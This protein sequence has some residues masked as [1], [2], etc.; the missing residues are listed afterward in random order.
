MS[1]PDFLIIGAMKSGT[2]T[3]AAQLS[4]QNGIFVTTPKEPN[5]FSDDSVFAKG[6]VWYEALFSNAGPDEIKGEA[7]TH[8]TKLPTYPKTVERAAEFLE[9]PKLVYIIRNPID[10]AISHYMHEWTMGNVSGDI[11]LEFERS[12]EILDYGCYGMQ[13]RPWIESFGRHAVHLVCLEEMQ[14]DP[15]RVLS[16]VAEFLG[17]PEQV[18]WCLERSNE[19]SSGIRYRAFPLQKY[20]IE[21]KIATAIRR[22]LV[23]QAVRSRIKRKRSMKERPELTK[24]LRTTLETRYTEDYFTLIN[25]FPRHEGVQL[26]YPFVVRQLD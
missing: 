10:R 1:M 15:Q 3:L 18:N 8:Y 23:P 4:E 2:T 7:S 22:S 5:F 16:E 25:F 17:H 19:N 13:V 20:I 26:S 9:S 11:E 24:S 14:H 6:R 21:S 12:P